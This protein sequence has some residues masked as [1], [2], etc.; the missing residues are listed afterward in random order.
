M[1]AGIGPVLE[2]RL[3]EAGFTSY[4]HLAILDEAG[5]EAL[6]GPMAS[7]RNRIRREH[8]VVQAK[9]L[10]LAKHGEQL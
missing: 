3:Q 4:R 9:K 1:I 10:H 8:W 5:L 2:R 7:L 6:S